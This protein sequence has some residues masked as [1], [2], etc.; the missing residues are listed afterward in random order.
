LVRVKIC[1][2]T[3]IEDAHAAVSA[4]AD[5]LGFVF[6]ESP[7]QVNAKTVLSIIGQLPPFVTTIGVFANQTA[8]EIVSAMREANLNFAQLHGEIADLGVIGSELGC[9]RL[10]RGLRMKSEADLHDAAHSCPNCGCAGILL[11][12]HVDGMMGGTGRTFDWDLAVKAHSLNKPI[13]LAGGLNP[14]NVSDAIQKVRPYAVDVS[15]GVEASPGK[16]DWEKIKEFVHN[17]KKPF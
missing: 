4:G 1:G 5:A 16:K 12:A 6:A 17:A 15:T 2:I 7:R 14:S 10:I 9:R 3:N 13:I 8:E 11:D